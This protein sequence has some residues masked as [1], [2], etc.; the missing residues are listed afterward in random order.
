MDKIRV[1]LVDDHQVAREGL[2]RMLELEDDMIIV[3]EASNGDEAL[4]KLKELSPQVT[5]MDIQMPGVDG[6][7]L[8]KKFKET[9][10][11]CNIIM[12]TLYDDYLTEAIDAG[13]SGYLLKDVKREEL[14]KAIHTVWQGRSHL[15]LSLSKEQLSD[16]TSQGSKKQNM[17]TEREL[18]ILQMVA[19]GI[20]TTEIASQLFLSPASIKRSVSGRPW[21][22]WGCITA[23]RPLPRLTNGIYYKNAAT[24]VNKKLPIIRL[25]THLILKYILFRLYVLTELYLT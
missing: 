19:N 18:K 24:L 10:P 22:N 9:Y 12:L 23:L 11:A 15:N 7:E 4:T 8:A 14:I 1:L 6:I 16:L 17:L 13:A 5:L 20:T 3:G 25:Y 21:I 2:R